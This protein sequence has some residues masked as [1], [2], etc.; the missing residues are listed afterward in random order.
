VASSLPSA[1][2]SLDG[3]DDASEDPSSTTVVSVSTTARPPDPQ[4]PATPPAPAPD[5]R[6]AYR[7][8]LGDLGLDD[9]LAISPV[10]RPPTMPGVAPLTGLA[11]APPTRPAVLVKIDNTSKARP[12]LGLNRA[13][14]VIEEEVEWGLTRLAAI[15][16]SNEASV[17]GPVRS[18]RSTDIAFFGSLN[19]PALVYSG[20]NAVFDQLMLEQPVQNFSAARNGG[21]WRDNSRRAPSNL[22]TDTRSFDDRGQ[23]PGSWFHY[24]SSAVTGGSASSSFT[25]SYPATTVQWDWDGTRWL[26]RQDGKRHTTDSGAQVEAANVIVVEVAKVDSGLVDPA[27]AVVPEFVWAGEGAATVYSNGRRIDGRWIRPTLRDPAIFVD[28]AGAP[29][30][31]T[32]GITWVQMVTTR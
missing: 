27:G 12:Q 6:A 15:F 3:D 4:R 17:V 20:A 23:G 29:I 10:P 28:A 2:P 8:V 18:A 25:V 31:I 1:D 5:A 11:P 30:A 22:F 19:N 24:A 7:G 26:R 13:D 14:V 9:V 16:H 21:F 32:P